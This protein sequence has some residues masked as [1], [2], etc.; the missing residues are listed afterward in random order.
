MRLQK[1]SIYYFLDTVLIS[2]FAIDLNKPCLHLP[3]FK[4]INNLPLLTTCETH[5]SIPRLMFPYCLLKPFHNTMTA[6]IMKQLHL[7]TSQISNESCQ[8]QNMIL[9]KGIVIYA[10]VTYGKTYQL[11]II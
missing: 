8:F 2:L 5:I 6:L 1:K 9:H 10:S 7:F 11:N 4:F 3:S